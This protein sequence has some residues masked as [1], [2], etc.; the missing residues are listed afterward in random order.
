MAQGR[1]LLR[2]AETVLTSFGRQTGPQ[3]ASWRLNEPLHR[4]RCRLSSAAAQRAVSNGRLSVGPSVCPAGRHRIRE[5]GDNETDG[6]TPRYGHSGGECPFENGPSARQP[7]PPPV[8]PSVRSHW[9]GGAAPLSRGAVK[10]DARAEPCRVVSAIAS[11]R[12]G[13]GR[14]PSANDRVTGVTL[15]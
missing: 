6:L 15:E 4:H 7:P 10:G 12:V 11:G 1:Q 14:A 9:G 2:R 5:R 13:A 3:T 8:R